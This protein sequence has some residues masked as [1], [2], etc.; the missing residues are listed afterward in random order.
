M[1]QGDLFGPRSAPPPINRLE[2]FCAAVIRQYAGASAVPP[3][4]LAEALRMHFAI[5][6]PVVLSAQVRLAQQLGIHDFQFVELPRGCSG[7]NSQDG[8]FYT[9]WVSTLDHR[10]RQEH[11]IFHELYELIHRKLAEQLPTLI[12]LSSK[13]RERNAD[14]FAAAVF[15][16]TESFA[17]DV[18][19]CGLDVL[20]LQNLYQRS[21]SSTLIGIK[22]SLR[23]LGIPFVGLLYED[24]DFADIEAVARRRL[25][26]IEA[27]IPLQMALHYRWTILG[28][29][30]KVNP[31]LA[32]HLPRSGDMVVP[33]SLAR[34]VYEHQ[35]A[36]YI[37]QATGFD[38]FGL[39]D[40]TV[41]LRP[42]IWRG[43]TIAKIIILCIRADQGDLLAPQIAGLHCHTV[44]HIAG[45]RAPLFEIS[46]QLS[47][48]LTPPI[49]SNRARVAVS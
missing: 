16:P 48:E 4:E 20:R 15:M 25:G 43:S 44:D 29:S 8:D 5:P 49:R 37:K 47:L 32:S 38:F 6:V 1:I 11:T 24:N 10:V 23:R 40:M 27:R 26:D 41:L 45:L 36:V 18:L 7:Y 35:S 22:D 3:S 34:M 30:A 12:P 39:D 31:I 13:E 14:E 28:M 17:K 21:Y 33:G 42:V 2:E 46:R 9:L 19:T